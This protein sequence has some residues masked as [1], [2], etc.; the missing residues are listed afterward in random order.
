MPRGR[1]SPAAA[2]SR[3]GLAARPVLPAPAPAPAAGMQVARLGPGLARRKRLRQRPG[4]NRPRGLT[5][6]ARAGPFPPLASSEPPS[7]ASRASRSL[8]LPRRSRE[9]RREGGRRLPGP[10]RGGA[11]EPEAGRRRRPKLTRRP[12]WVRS[13]AEGGE[14]PGSGT[15]RAGRS[16]ER[17]W[18]VGTASSDREERRGGE[19]RREGRRG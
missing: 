10:T 8:S 1:L 17:G 18:G 12:S 11:Q 7:A 19:R 9:R 3:G 6:E 13:S 4:R 16:R 2:A 14:A 15:A 5:R